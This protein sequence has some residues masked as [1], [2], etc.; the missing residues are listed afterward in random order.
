MPNP[1]PN[2]DSAPVVE[3]ELQRRL[4][5][6]AGSW[7]DTPVFD[8]DLL[9]ESADRLDH[10][11]ARERAGRELARVADRSDAVVFDAA[12]EEWTVPMRLM[13]DILTHLDGGSTDA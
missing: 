10:L 8:C 4:R 3:G 2:A 11:E 13:E 12:G 9:I 6:S 7:C 5:I 1:T